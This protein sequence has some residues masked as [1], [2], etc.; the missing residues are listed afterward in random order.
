MKL[1]EM[2]NSNKPKGRVNLTGG[3]WKVSVL[4][5]SCEFRA[6]CSC[7]KFYFPFNISIKTL[8]QVNCKSIDQGNLLTLCR[9]FVYGHFASRKGSRLPVVF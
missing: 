7:Y 8:P 9:M 5:R 3:V 6:L 4:G 2:E 1:S